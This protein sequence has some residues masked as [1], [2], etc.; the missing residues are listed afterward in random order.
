M[1]A[2][3]STQVFLSRRNFDQL[4]VIPACVHC[5]FIQ[6]NTL[7]TIQKIKHLDQFNRRDVSREYTKE[8]AHSTAYLVMFVGNG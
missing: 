1:Y 3:I 8:L 2:R 7:N 5:S 4:E 6:K